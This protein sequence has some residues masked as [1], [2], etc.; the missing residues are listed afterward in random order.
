MPLGLFLE[1]LHPTLEGAQ[2]DNR[3]T[4]IVGGS[5]Q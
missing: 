2:T 3:L 1:K 5:V 4:Y